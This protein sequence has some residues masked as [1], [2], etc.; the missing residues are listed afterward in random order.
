M[1]L[2][3]PGRAR[4]LADGRRAGLKGGSRGVRTAAQ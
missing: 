4:R 3:K 1:G 2:P